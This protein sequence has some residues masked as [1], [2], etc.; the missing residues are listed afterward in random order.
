M[1]TISKRDSIVV[2]QPRVLLVQI[3]VRER[4]AQRDEDAVG[5]ERLL[6]DVVRAE[7]RRLDRGLDRARAR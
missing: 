1:P 2:A 7:L 4:V 3:E 6:E 5:V